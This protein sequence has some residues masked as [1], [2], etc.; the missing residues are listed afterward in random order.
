M[1]RHVAAL[2]CVMLVVVSCVAGVAEARVN[3]KDAR[4]AFN[5]IR[6]SSRIPK[7][8]AASPALENLFRMIMQLGSSSGPVTLLVPADMGY[9]QSRLNNRVFTPSQ[10]NSIRKYHLLDGLVKLAD[11]QALPRGSTVATL[12]GSTIKKIT[13][14]SL[15][16]V[17]LKGRDALPAMVVAGDVYV[18]STLAVHVVST[19]LIPSDV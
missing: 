7:A 6:R 18:G 3:R 12:E 16:V 15:P 14:P 9:V 10:L 1:A 11:I 13:P 2:L 17:L 4:R 8:L 5:A 19:M